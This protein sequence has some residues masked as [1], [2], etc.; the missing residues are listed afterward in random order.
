MKTNEYPIESVVPHEHP[1]ILV[2]ELLQYDQNK[3]ICKVTITDQSNFYDTEM[4]S[5]PSYV[6]IEYMAQSI[7]AFANANNKDKNIDVAIGFLVSSRKFKMMVSEFTLNTILEISVEQLYLEESGLAAFDCQVEMAGEIVATAKIN[8][9][10][11]KN[12][13]DFLAEQN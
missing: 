3:A 6:A 5:V 10:Q 8:I 1:M 9:F 12:P 2:D 13:E 7:A 4:K 11:P